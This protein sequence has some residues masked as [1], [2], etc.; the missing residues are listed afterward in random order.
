MCWMG[1]TVA[2]NDCVL[3]MFRDPAR[4][5]RKM[6]V[7]ELNV[8]NTVEEI[9]GFLVVNGRTP[10]NKAKI[11][12]LNFLSKL[13]VIHSQGQVTYVSTSFICY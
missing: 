9:I 4:K 2:L 12:R 7:A 3:F 11:R 13:R 1:Y 6:D 5:I 10:R 8:L